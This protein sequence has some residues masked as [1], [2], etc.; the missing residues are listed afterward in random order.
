MLRVVLFLATNL[1]VLL[2]ASVI[3]SLLGLSTNSMSGL[4]V[5]CALFG[6]GGAL[7]SLFISKW[8]AKRSVGAIVIERPENAEQ[9]WLVETVKDLSQKAGIGM[10]EVAMFHSPQSNAF[11]TGWNKNKALVA[12]SDSLL[13]RMSREEVKA[14]LGHE[15]GHIANGDMVTLTLIQGVVNTFVMF[16]ARIIGQTV[17]S[18]LSSDEEGE[19]SGY[20]IAYFV[21]TIIAEICLGIL[22]SILVAWFSRRREFRADEAGASLVSNTA[23]IGALQALQR[24]QEMPEQMPQSLMAFGINKGKRK[25]L[26]EMFSSHPPLDVRINALRNQ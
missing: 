22:A 2:V 6:F 18:F 16:F 5:F 25:G 26:A 12:V 17:D 8:M 15:I 10:P 11:A 23:M 24:E 7:L 4:L 3:M 20:G 13:Q 1:A 14:V 19:S 21:T 9:Q